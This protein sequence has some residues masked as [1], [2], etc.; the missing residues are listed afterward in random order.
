VNGFSAGR[1]L[2]THHEHNLAVTLIGHFHRVRTNSF[3]S[4]IAAIQQALREA[5]NSS[6]TI[7]VFPTAPHTFVE[8]AKSGERSDGLVSLLA[9]QTC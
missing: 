4:S 3:H 7:V 5:R 9:M 2:Q 8:L 6:Y 1:N